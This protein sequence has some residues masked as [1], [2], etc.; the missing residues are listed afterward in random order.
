MDTKDILRYC[1]GFGI[2]RFLKILSD[3]K[4]LFSDFDVLK[5]ILRNCNVF[6]GF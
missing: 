4:E 2:K 5:G 3:F 6:E 1:F